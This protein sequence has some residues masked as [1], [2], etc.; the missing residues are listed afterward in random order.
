VTE[1]TPDQ[2]LKR[3]WR[4]RLADFLPGYLDGHPV[5]SPFRARASVILHGSTTMGID[6][7]FSDLDLWLLLPAAA[8]AEL[9]AAAGT[10]FFEFRLD[11]KQGHLNA[12]ST[13]AFAGRAHGC[14]MD[15]IYQLRSA[16]IITDNTGAGGELIRLA[17][18]PMREEVSQAFFFYH[19]V[20]MRGEH[21]ACDNP[22]QRSDPVALLLSLPKVIA[23][24]LQAAMVLDGQ[25]YPY[26]KWLYRAAGGTPTGRLLTPSVGKVLDLLAAGHLRTGPPESDHPVSLELRVIRRILVEAAQ[27][28]GIREPWLTQWWLHMHQ[29]QAAI[30][31]VRW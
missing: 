9:C 28:K 4:R 3:P 7:D 16:E 19:Y 30:Q 11:G 14:H 5:L 31:N 12:E 25:P 6:D 29:A 10:R 13:A 21:R 26:D 22:I 17:R 2:D 1:P 27:A 24:A 18:R 8:T 20:E 15:T 23:H